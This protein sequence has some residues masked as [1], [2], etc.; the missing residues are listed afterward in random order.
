AMPA[1]LGLPA[2]DPKVSYYNNLTFAAFLTGGAL[3]GVLFGA[4]ADRLGRKRTMTATILLYSLFTSLS[5][6]A[7]TWWQMAGFRLLVPRGVGGEGAAPGVL[8]W[9]VS[10]R[11]ARARTQSIFHASSVLGT[12]LA[13]IVGALIVAQPVI[14]IPLLGGSWALP[15]WRVG[16][17]LGAAPALL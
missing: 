3:G 7:E 1:L 13:V 6:F 11:R 14:A 12:Y 17:L 5:A 8:A 4:L 15:G 2:R 10:P 9:G 16:F